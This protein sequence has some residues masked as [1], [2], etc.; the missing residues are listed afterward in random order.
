MKIFNNK[1]DIGWGITSQCNMNCEFC[2]S[3]SAR[4]GEEDI[5]LKRLIKFIDNNNDKIASINFGT[6]ENSLLDDWFTL[7]AYIKQ[8]YPTISI[9]VTT[10]GFLGHIANK[11]DRYKKIIKECI[12]EIDVSLDFAN[13]LKHNNIRGNPNAF[14]WVLE[15]LKLASDISITTT[16]VFIGLEETL[17]FDNIHKLF[18][19]AKDYGAFVRLNIYRPTNPNIKP[20]PIKIIY[21]ALDEI[22]STY[23]VVSLADPLFSAL[24]SDRT[25]IDASGYNSLRILPDGSITPSTYLVQKEWKAGHIFEENILEKI[26]ERIQFINIKNIIPVACKDCNLLKRCKGG[27][28]DRRILTFGNLNEKDPLCDYHNKDLKIKSKAVYTESTGTPH[29][30]DGYLPTLIF[31]SNKI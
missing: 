18:K 16:I 13:Q 11:K 4:N 19:I 3:K 1:W 27:A 15:T 9:A 22:I 20:P 6:G 31:S 12:N 10:N 17:M 5:T 2:Y 21:N 23:Q 30:H 7:I 24:F 28:K 8:T 29:I 25:S 26:R 14:N